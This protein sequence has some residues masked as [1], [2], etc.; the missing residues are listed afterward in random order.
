[1]KPLHLAMK[2]KSLSLGMFYLLGPELIPCLAEAG[3]NHIVL[4][5]MFSR[6]DWGQTADVIAQARLAGL[7]PVLRVQTYPWTNDANGDMGAV[8]E[9]ARARTNGALGA[10]VSIGSVEQLKACMRV[11]ND[12]EHI[13]AGHQA[14]QAERYVKGGWEAVKATMPDESKDFPIVAYIEDAKLLNVL[15]E[16]VSVD[17]LMAVGLGIHDICYSVLG[18]PFDVEHPAVWEI[19]DKVVALAKPRGIS[20]WTNTGYIFN[21]PDE[22]AERIERLYNRGVDTIQVQFP[23]QLLLPLLSEI[24][25]KAEAIVEGRPAPP[26][27]PTGM[28]LTALLRSMPSGSN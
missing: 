28:E 18:Q 7:S 10:V 22:T 1:M 8:S 19:I 3:F 12:M 4:D 11:A 2:D 21:R 17:G 14:R 15:D 25:A 16:I 27:R 6:M 13:P 20:V 24:V 23:A 5:H 9:V 26:A